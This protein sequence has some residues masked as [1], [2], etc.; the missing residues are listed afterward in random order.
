M[1]NSDAGG[2]SSFTDNFYK[3]FVNVPEEKEESLVSLLEEKVITATTDD[4]NSSSSSSS[5]VTQPSPIAADKF[6]RRNHQRPNTL[7]VDH[8]NSVLRRSFNERRQQQTQSLD[9]QKRSLSNQRLY[10]ASEH[11][12]A[13]VV[14]AATFVS[15]HPERGGHNR[16]MATSCS[17]VLVN[18]LKKSN[19]E[20]FEQQQQHQ[21]Q[22]LHSPA[23]AASTIIARRRSSSLAVPKPMLF[24]EFT[25]PSTT[26]S[27][28][29]NGTITEKSPLTQHHYHHHHQQ[30]QPSTIRSVSPKLFQP[31]VRGNNS[32]NAA[33]NNVR[34]QAVSSITTTATTATT[35][36][37][38]RTA[39]MPAV[40][41]GKVSIREFR[42]IAY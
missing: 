40:T 1:I 35:L 23:T 11:Q 30:H 28:G 32:N 25:P 39:S 8:R 14:V 24:S 17:D 42:C 12:P 4:T 16:S 7:M 31:N 29:I 10:S 13:S 22:L 36:Q 34:R 9:H 26:A 20:H 27:T 41:R 5:C 21:Q 6:R 18:S 33:V 19:Y 3:I 15:N 2:L 38:N 37:R